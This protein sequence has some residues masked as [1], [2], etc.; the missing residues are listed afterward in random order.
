M[1]VVSILLIG[2]IICLNLALVI[3]YI[4]VHESAHVQIFSQFGCDSRI[5]WLPDGALA[6]TIPDGNCMMNEKMS[7]MHSL[8][9]IVGYNMFVILIVLL[10]IMDFLGWLICGKLSQDK[11]VRI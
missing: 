2:S 6:A 4:G 8:N 9:D 5:E 3:A 10:I 7:E 11:E 1:K